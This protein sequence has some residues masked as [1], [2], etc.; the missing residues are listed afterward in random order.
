M[1]R[2]LLRINKIYNLKKKIK[3]KVK[4]TTIALIIIASVSLAQITQEKVLVSEALGAATFTE[5]ENSGEKYFYIDEKNISIEIFNLDHSIF[6]S[7]QLDTVVMGLVGYPVWEVDLYPYCLSENLF[8][9]DNEVE[10]L[11]AIINYSQ[12]V[13]TRITKTIIV[14]EDGSVIFDKL[15]QFPAF[16]GEGRSQFPD[17][18]KNTE[19]GTKMILEGDNDSLFIYGLPGSVPCKT[20][21]SS[22]ATTNKKS[23]EKAYDIN[24]FP[25]PTTNQITLAINTDKTGMKVHIYSTDGRL[26]KSASV[27]NGNNLIDTADLVAG[28]YI[29]NVQTDSEVMHASQFIKK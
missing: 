9:D 10:V 7:I 18:I 14:N 19:E 2:S 17:W 6:K 22:E 16:T 3:M 21:S 5:L 25:N 24:V 28:T 27:V 12:D 26:V 15:N 8:D 11:L 29:Y 13:S 20:C 4:L 1:H 23:P